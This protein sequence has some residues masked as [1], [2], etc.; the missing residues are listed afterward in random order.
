MQVYSAYYKLIQSKLKLFYHCGADA[1]TIIMRLCLPSQ[2]HPLVFIEPHAG[3]ST[4]YMHLPYLKAFVVLLL[5][6]ID[7]TQAII[8]YMRIENILPLVICLNYFG[9]IITEF[10]RNC[11]GRKSIVIA[12]FH[13]LFSLYFYCKILLQL[14]WTAS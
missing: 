3:H 13:S 7:S 14:N 9:T 5:A 11:D 8:K 2:Y 10:N 12:V 4:P 6:S 1:V